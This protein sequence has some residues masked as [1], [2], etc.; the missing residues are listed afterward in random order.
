MS[1]CAA[2]RRLP[3][4]SPVKSKVSRAPAG[5]ERAALAGVAKELVRLGGCLAELEHEMRGAIERVPDE[6]RESARNLV[7]YVAL[8][9]N[10]LRDLQLQLTQ[11]GLSSLGRSESWVRGS[12]LEA[13]RHV[14]ESLALRGDAGAKRELKRLE[15]ESD[16]LFAWEAASR[17]LHEHTREML[18]PRPDD[19][20]VY[21]MVTAPPA[22]EADL[23]W[24]TK[25][26]R[27]GMN[28]LRINCAHDGP[29]GGCGW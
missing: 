5:Q 14:H 8:R 21:I 25:M 20:H 16:V 4:G 29:T 2:E 22:K 3:C 17:S 26:L 27:A 1:G 24:M 13:S 12:L 9:Q 7:R 19:R 18:G 23:A 11:L 15:S 10:D 6:R 28:V